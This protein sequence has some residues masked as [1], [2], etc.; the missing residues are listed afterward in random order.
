MKNYIIVCKLIYISH[1]DTKDTKKILY[2]MRTEDR[3][4]RR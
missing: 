1:K 4:I 3:N 2:N